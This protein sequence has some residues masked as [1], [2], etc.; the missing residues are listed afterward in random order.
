MFGD[1]AAIGQRLLG[2]EAQHHHRGR[3]VLMQA[4]DHARHRL[5]RDQGHV[6]VEDQHVALEPGQCG[7]GLQHGVRGAQLLGLDRD[8]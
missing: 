2:P 1:H 4:R 7:L 8:P 5:G 6:A 3:I